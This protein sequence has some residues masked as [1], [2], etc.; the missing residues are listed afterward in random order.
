[1]LQK[2]IS[3]TNQNSNR[4]T[5]KLQFPIFHP[6]LMT[7]NKGRNTGILKDLRMLQI[8]QCLI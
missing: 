1:M 4:I 8:K 7:K 6:F 5:S 3:K 2:T